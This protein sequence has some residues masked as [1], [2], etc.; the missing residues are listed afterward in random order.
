MNLALKLA[1]SGGRRIL[2]KIKQIFW[3][4]TAMLC[5]LNLGM[6][7]HLLLV[8]LYQ[9]S[10]VSLHQIYLSD[11]IT[12]THQFTTKFVYSIGRHRIR[13]YPPQGSGV[14]YWFVLRK[15]KKIVFSETTGSGALIHVVS[16]LPMQVKHFYK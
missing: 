15:H 6:Q 8:D 11:S 12:G 14:L 7:H 16:I 1:H 3:S 2:G 5:A 4:E 13:K 10:L 9:V